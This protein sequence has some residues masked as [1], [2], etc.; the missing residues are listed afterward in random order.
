[1]VEAIAVP[2]MASSKKLNTFAVIISKHRVGVRHA[3]NQL[4]FNR[5]MLLQVGLIGEKNGAAGTTTVVRP[6]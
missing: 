5:S 2:L 6:T 3:R 4:S 1:M